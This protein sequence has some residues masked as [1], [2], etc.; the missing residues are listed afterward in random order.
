VIITKKDMDGKIIAYAEFKLVDEAGKEHLRGEYVWIN[1]VWVHKAFRTRDVFNGILKN[2]IAAGA[3]SF[4]W[5]NYI[6]WQREKHNERMS[7]YDKV[8]I[9]RRILDGE[10]RGRRT[11]NHDNADAHPGAAAVCSSF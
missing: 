2:F 8:T 6:Y 3:R 11:A 7:L 10:K 9:M 4:P 5:A 1:Q